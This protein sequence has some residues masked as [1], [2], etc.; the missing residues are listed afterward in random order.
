MT[1]SPA[2][3]RAGTAVTDDQEMPRGMQRPGEIIAASLRQRIAAGEWAPGEPLPTVAEL[4]AEYHVARA[5]VARTLR[6]LEAEGLVRV[7]SRWGTFRVEP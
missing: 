2:K 7:I 1:V 6:L 5:T 3:W 4:A